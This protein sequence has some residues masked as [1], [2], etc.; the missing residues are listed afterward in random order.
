QTIHNLEDQ[1]YSSARFSDIYQEAQNCHIADSDCFTAYSGMFLNTSDWLVTLVDSYNLLKIDLELLNGFSIGTEAL[2]PAQLEEIEQNIATSR[3]EAAE[4]GIRSAHQAVV[5]LSSALFDNSLSLANQTLSR[6]SNIGLSIAPFSHIIPDI[7]RAKSKND[8]YSLNTLDDSLRQLNASILGIIQIRSA[9][10]HFSDRGIDT[11]KI[12]DLLE[13][14]SYYLAKQDQHR[15]LELAKS[16]DEE[17]IAATAFDVKYRKV[18]ARFSNIVDFSDA[19]RAA[20]ANGLNISYSNYLAADFERANSML[21]KTE[22]ILTDLQS[23]QAVKRSLES[24]GVTMQE[25]IKRNVYVILS[26]AAVTILLIYLF[27]RNISLYLAKRRLAHLEA[28]KS[29]L[30][31]MI[32]KI[33]KSHYVTHEMPRRPYVTRLRQYQRKLIEISRYSLLIN[34]KITKTGKQTAKVADEASKLNK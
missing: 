26:V 31:E 7:E 23:A 12:D 5:S 33:Q 19:D 32:K 14:G 28:E 1:G 22:G 34:E 16:A 11:K 15:V 25:M 9:R 2:G 18:E 6:I 20:V 4:Q 27:S 17:Y 10:D 8:L 24:S 21:D 30:I 3:Y 13:E 29:N